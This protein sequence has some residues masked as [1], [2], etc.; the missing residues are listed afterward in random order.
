MA[1]KWVEPFPISKR[2]DEFGNLAP[3]REGR[4]HRGLDWS[5]PAGSLI[6]AIASGAIKQVDWSEG[7]GWFVIQSADGGK[8]F[9]IYAHLQEK[10]KLTVGKF[11]YAG[12][13]AI[14]RVGST[15]KFSTGAHLHLSV[16]TVEDVHLCS[17]DKLVDPADLF[18][19]KG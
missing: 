15:G 10:P 11:I 19:L 2:G 16:A 13:T 5:V 7:L 9:V 8:K 3:Y 4:P 17:Y 12:K 1:T 18:E 14:G 6:K